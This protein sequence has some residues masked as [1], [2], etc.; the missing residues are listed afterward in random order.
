M[1]AEE[2]VLSRL[3]PDNLSIVSVGETYW[4][5]CFDEDDREV[6]EG[7]KGSTNIEEWLL[8]WNVEALDKVKLSALTP[9]TTRKL[10]PSEIEEFERVKAKLLRAK[11]YAANYW[12]NEVYKEHIP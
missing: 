8:R 6:E 4:L 12:E 2:K 1:N 3:T 5:C 7:L 9:Y 10:R 11:M